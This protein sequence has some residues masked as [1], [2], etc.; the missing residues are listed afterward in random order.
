MALVIMVQTCSLRTVA[1]LFLSSPLKCYSKE[2][3]NHTFGE[4][5][6]TCSIILKLLDMQI[7]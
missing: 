2:Q 5:E 3:L 7:M 6:K 4:E 1:N